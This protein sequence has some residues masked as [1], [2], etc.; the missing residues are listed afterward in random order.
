MEGSEVRRAYERLVEEIGRCTKCPLHLSRKRAVPGEGPLDADVMLVG[1]APGR[2]EDDTG[3]PFV[4]PAGRLLTA[5]LESIGLRRER[6]YITNVVKCR[7][8]NNRDPSEEELGAC[9]GYLLEQI[10]LITPR[11]IVLLGRIAGKHV[12]S[13]AGLKW[14]GVREARGKIVPASIGGVRVR[15]VA[16]FHP[17]AAL[18]NP[19][20]RRELEED[21]KGPVR[22]AVSGEEGGKKRTLT[23]YM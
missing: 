20:L 1:E 17:A 22:E 10:R 23:D 6:V 15:L 19:A 16:T 18:Y 3:R 21:F 4:G 12:Y 11:T 5:L 14:P 8:P 13:L 7:P 2:V 9:A